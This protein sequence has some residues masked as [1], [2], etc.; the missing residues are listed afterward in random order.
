M[1]NYS[2]R[3]GDAQQEPTALATL[4]AWRGGRIANPPQVH[5]LPHKKAVQHPARTAAVQ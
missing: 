5:N 4:P 3:P 2:I 1:V